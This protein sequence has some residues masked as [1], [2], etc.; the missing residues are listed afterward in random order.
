MGLAP[1]NVDVGKLHEMGRMI[2]RDCG[3]PDS[4]EFFHTNPVQMF[5]FSSLGL[6]E[7]PCK[8]LCGHGS[9]VESVPNPSVSCPGTAMVFPIGDALQEPLWTSGLGVNRGFHGGL[10][11][12]HAALLAREQDFDAA[13]DSIAHSWEC[14]LKM[15]WGDGRLAGGGSGTSGVRPG[16]KWTAEPRSR[17]PVQV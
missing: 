8:F 17:L 11:A 2:A 6:C 1:D 9:V 12:V 3:L 10:N 16:D 7:L 13:S 15:Q 4:A 5:D 14:M